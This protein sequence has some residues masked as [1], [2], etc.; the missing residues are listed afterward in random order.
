MRAVL[1][2]LRSLAWMPKVPELQ[3]IIFSGMCCIVTEFLVPTV[4][5]PGILVVGSEARI[6]PVRGY[7]GR[8]A[9]KMI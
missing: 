5:G 7:V 3:Y 9:D 1:S 4:F 6:W 2:E 8:F